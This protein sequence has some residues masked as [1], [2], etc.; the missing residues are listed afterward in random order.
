MEEL[1]KIESQFVV[2]LNQSV[3]YLK[4]NLQCIFFHANVHRKT[5]NRRCFWSKILI[6]IC[7]CKLKISSIFDISI[8]VENSIILTEKFIQI[9]E[10][11]VC[12][13]FQ[14]F[15]MFFQCFSRFNA[16]LLSCD[17]I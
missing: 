8:L 2:R 11:S 5:Q 4:F 6:I 13:I 7:K 14:C 1:S 3:C 17:Q 15:A 16:Y 9:F 12:E 10:V